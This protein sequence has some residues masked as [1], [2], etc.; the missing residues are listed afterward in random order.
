MEFAGD[1]N[2]TVYQG[3]AVLPSYTTSFRSGHVRA[4]ETH[5]AWRTTS[6]GQGGAP[7]SRADRLQGLQQQVPTLQCMLCSTG[8]IRCSGPGPMMNT[9][10]MIGQYDAGLARQRFEAAV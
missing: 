4:R 10:Y 7:P 2:N 5:G 1:T 3:G 8:K 6:I 9:G